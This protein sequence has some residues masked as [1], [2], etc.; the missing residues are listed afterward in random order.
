LRALSALYKEHPDLRGKIEIV[1]AGVFDDND[2][3]LVSELRLDD[4]VQILG[5]LPHAES[6]KLLQS[7]DVLF[8]THF[9][10]SDGT[11]NPFIGGKTYEYMASG[12][13]ILALLPES[14]AKDFVRESGL[15]IFCPQKNIEAIKSTLLNLYRQHMSGGI[16]VS[17]NW[18]FIQ[19][20]KRRQLTRRLGEI[21]DSVIAK[22]SRSNWAKERGI[23]IQNCSRWTSFIK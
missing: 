8:L 13:P 2:R 17:A 20:F 1:F 23:R 5:Y 14:D 9:N 18:D 19:Q 11:R 6:V 4:S 12:K 22:S 10:F 7:A 15:G 16:S 3:R 21:F